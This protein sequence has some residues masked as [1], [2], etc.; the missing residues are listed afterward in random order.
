M[1]ANNIQSQFDAAK[2]E[3]PVGWHWLVDHL[4]RRVKDLSIG[5]LKLLDT[6]DR[7]WEKPEKPF[8]DLT[9][10]QLKQ[11]MG[12]LRIHLFI[13]RAEFDWNKFDQEDYEQRFLPTP[14]LGVQ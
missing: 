8:F 4:A 6:K 3:C 12:E 14:I 2:F 9:V 13:D 11:K 5:G 1:E 10:S 7:G